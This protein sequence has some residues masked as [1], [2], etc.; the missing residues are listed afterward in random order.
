MTGLGAI[1]YAGLMVAAAIVLVI[2][3]VGGFVLWLAARAV[4]AT[5]P[6]VPPP[7]QAERR[8]SAGLVVIAAMISVSPLSAAILARMLVGADAAPRDTT[9]VA[10]I[11]TALGTL[12]VAAAWQLRHRAALS[13]VAGLL[14]VVIMVPAAIQI[15]MTSQTIAFAANYR[16][17]QELAGRRAARYADMIDGPSVGEI[18]AAVG[19]V[20]SWRAVAGGFQPFVRSDEWTGSQGPVADLSGRTVR[21]AVFVQCWIEGD[22]GEVQ[23]DVTD[24]DLG[25][26]WSTRFGRCD[27][28][29]QELVSDPVKLAAWPE[30]RLAAARA[31]ERDLIAVGAM[32]VTADGARPAGEYAVRSI[33]FVSIDPAT[34]VDALTASVTAAAGSF[35]IR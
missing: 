31:H 15:W 6:H 22:R 33:I 28:T 10:L 5:G 21:L 9:M 23:V 14:V 26:L 35:D 1:Y 8:V 25:S 18:V 7:S 13:Y 12:S 30:G 34:S 19:E 17:A 29:M 24:Y 3:L 11:V 2:V 4:R 20:G 16:A 27:G 32:P